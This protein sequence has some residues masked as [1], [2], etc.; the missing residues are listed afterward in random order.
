MA[1]WIWPVL[2][3]SQMGCREAREGT[4][5]L[6]FAC[7]HPVL[8]QLPA[9][10]L[11]GFL[12]AAAM[13]SGVLLRFIVSG[14]TGSLLTWLAAAAFIPSLA[15]ML[16]VVT[17]SSKVFEVVYL[18]LCY[19]GPMSGVAGLDFIAARTPGVPSVWFG[20]A[21]ASLA[22]ATLWRWRQLAR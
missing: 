22:I 4:G 18:M 7:G 20:C 10:W 9:Q 12:L 3:W 21:A 19:A 5:E 11:A 8:M 13:G 17:A 2:R 1:A 14:D 16:G 15:L 6:V